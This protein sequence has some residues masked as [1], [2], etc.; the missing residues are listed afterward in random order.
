MPLAEALAIGSAFSGGNADWQAQ[1]SNGLQ[2]VFDDGVRMVLVPAGCFMMGSNDGYSDEQPV[3]QQ[4]FEAPFWIDRTEVTQA[5]FARLGGEQK[6]QSSFSGADRP[7]ET[8]TWFE[9]RDFCAL[10]GA[11]LPTEADW[12]YAARGPDGLVYPWGNAF[13]EDNAVW[14]RGFGEGTA[15]VGSRPAGR[16]W[17]G[18]DDMSGNVW[19]WTSS[20]Y[21][22]YPYAAGDGRE[23]DTG[24]STDVVRV[25]RGGSW[26]YDFSGNL[27]AADRDWL[28]PEVRN[29]SLGFRC[30]R[31]EGAAPSAM[32]PVETRQTSS[33]TALP[34]ATLSATPTPTAAQ[35]S[36]V[37]DGLIVFASDATGQDEIY[38]IRSD[39]SDLRQLTTGSG[40]TPSWSP[41]GE[42]I[43]YSAIQ[44]DSLDLFVMNA[45]GTN[46]RHLL[47]LPDTN[48]FGAKWS[49][50]GEY[51]AFASR[52]R[53]DFRDYGI[54]R[55]NADGSDLLKVSGLLDGNINVLPSWS[56]DSARIYFLS[57]QPFEITRGDPIALGLFSVA[58]DGSDL[59][60]YTIAAKEPRNAD[61]SPDGQGIL[62]DSLEGGNGYG[63]DIYYSSLTEEWAY[64]V[65]RSPAIDTYA[66]WSPTGS[67]I[68]FS[69]REDNR[70]V[71][72]IMRADSQFQQRLTNS[73]IGDELGA[74][75][76][77]TSRGSIPPT[78]TSTPTATATATSVPLA[79]D[80]S[81]C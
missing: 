20:L 77:P 5:D 23:A 14:N 21:E 15:P 68:V 11:R 63:Q 76:Q 79:A 41:D 29:I 43:V 55:I 26:N 40:G 66:S 53:D 17:V 1:Y 80:K 18:A 33:S 8:I 70:Y 37:P 73:T 45:D 71:L 50:N 65:S 30:A 39:G 78:P 19:E 64:A 31:S 9:A 52:A 22:S 28:N 59:L 42:Q 62:L 61:V 54:Y 60:E 3:H 36:E 34:T 10:R 27:R 2:Y 25:V 49:P 44:G 57:S 7:V 58:L 51:I 56:P 24:T 74:D 75:W 32:V 72:Y 4:C 47:S 67:H 13:D 48:E 35:S 81:F 38:T 69:R 12:E 16:S 46:Q 6:R